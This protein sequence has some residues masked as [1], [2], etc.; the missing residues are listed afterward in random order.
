MHLRGGREERKAARVAREGH[1][2][3]AASAS[4]GVDKGIVARA[5]AGETHCV[6]PSLRL[7]T[8]LQT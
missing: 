5:T 7:P 4:A 1:L 2:S 3:G 6:R 8:I